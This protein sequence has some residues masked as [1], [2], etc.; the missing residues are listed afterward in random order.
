MNEE[1][2]TDELNEKEKL[3][4]IKDKSL[5]KG[6]II[7]ILLY[8]VFTKSLDIKSWIDPIENKEQI[9]EKLS[10]MNYIIN[11]K[12]LYDKD[13]ERI[14]DEI[15][16]GMMAGIDDKY[17]AYYN[18]EE[19]AELVKN[20]EG[21]YSG[22]GVLVLEDPED[23]RLVIVK[24]YKD[25]PAEKAGIKEGDK[26]LRV[27]NVVMDGKERDDVIN[28]VKGVDGTIVKLGVYRKSDN[29]E[30]DLD[31]T[32]GKVDMP[33]VSYKMLDYQ[34]GYI[35]IDCFDGKAHPQLIEAKDAL[36]KEG[37]TGLVI[38]LRNNPGGN[39]EVLK[40]IADEF[41]DEGVITYFKDRDGKTEYH[42]SVDGK[43]E[44]PVTILI[45]EYTASAAEV[46]AA[47]LKDHERATIIGKT[48]YGKG[49][50]QEVFMLTDGTAIKFTVFEYFT[51]N[52]NQVNKV[53]VKPD[54]E[55]V[56]N[57]KTQIDEQIEEA[58]KQI[59]E[60]IKKE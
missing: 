35:K 4:S 11:S 13:L 5:I 31:V 39:L 49:I 1:N 16:R 51:P 33:M 58:Q 48:S 8:I 18:K 29:K 59:K 19:V 30:Y 7:G 9:I 23:H 2:K 52:G 27:D 56:D 26:I 46:F 47:A 15:D 45:N 17:A 57:E 3:Q 38:D 55:V 41:L 40:R 36:L 43:I 6:I 10:E 50:V 20:T 25:S 54:I 32:R 53:G 60:M 22:I 21:E 34:V 44:L 24:V 28:A 42:N 14:E 37:M 12:F